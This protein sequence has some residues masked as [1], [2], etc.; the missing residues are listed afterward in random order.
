MAFYYA[1][2]ASGSV[3]RT[4]CTSLGH[5]MKR[6]DLIKGGAL[7]GLGAMLPG[8][9]PRSA[10]AAPAPS[11]DRAPASGQVR[12]VIFYAYDG[13]GYE[14]LAAARFFSERVEGRPL[15][16]ERLLSEG[17]AGSMFP[18]SLTSVVTD[19][20]A[21]S[22]AWS[23]GRKVVNGAVSKYPD[24]RD[25]TTILELAKDRG[26]ATG[27]VTSTRITHATPACW[28]AHVENRGMEDEIAAQYLDFEPE[29]LL[30]G[31]GAHFD[32]AAREDG[33]DLFAEFSAKGYEVLRTSADLERSNGSRLLGTFTDGTHL[34]FEIDRR[35]QEVPSPSLADITRKGLDVLSGAD[36]GFVLQVEAGRID[37]ANHGNDPGALVHDWMAADEALGEI[38]DFVDRNP[39]TLLILAADHD[40]GGGAI[41]GLGPGYGLATQAFE[42]LGRR[43]ASHEYLFREVMGDAPSAADIREAVR[44]HLGVPVSAEQAAHLE[45]IVNREL[46]PAHASAQGSWASNHFAHALSEI[47]SGE[48]DRPNI[49]FAT[50]SHTGG[51]VPVLTYGAGV[52]PG[53]L[54]VVDNTEL[55][56]WMTDALGIDHRNPE[57]TEE[58]AL[59]MAGGRSVG[60][61]A[62]M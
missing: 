61:V 26:I 12:N 21:A 58:E 11:A 42:T 53:N 15:R 50:G 41:Y 39:D 57:M 47:P 45:Q 20:A 60:D 22:T 30:G 23:V 62:M 28:I 2:A 44:E 1:A 37:H 51:L 24:G 5:V 31:G 9:A 27:L 6:R 13:T 46:R 33:R 3:P 17:A 36:R 29:V 14:D 52:T 56:G 25:L 8:C 40:T 7:A 35:F 19:S 59:R 18:Y 49:G 43:R 48:A 54:G 10:V 4:H 38:V 32:P 16:L 34:P 55:F